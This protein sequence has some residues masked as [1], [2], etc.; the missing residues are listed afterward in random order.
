MAAVENRPIKQYDRIAHSAER[1]NRRLERPVLSVG[2]PRKKLG[3]TV[4]GETFHPV[5]FPIC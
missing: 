4:D 2:H 1:L 3:Q 5:H